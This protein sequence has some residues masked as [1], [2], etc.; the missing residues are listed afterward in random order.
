MIVNLKKHSSI[1]YFSDE[2]KIAYRPIILKNSVKTIILLKNRLTQSLFHAAG[3]WPLSSEILTIL[4][5]TSKR[6]S[7]HLTSRGVGM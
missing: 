7:M 6:T 1:G 4:V 2:G 3:K 5:L